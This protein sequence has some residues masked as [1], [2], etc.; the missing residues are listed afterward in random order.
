[1]CPATDDPASCKIHTVIGFLHAEIHHELCAV[2]GRNVMSKGTTR[3]WCRMVKDG[4]TNIKDEVRSGPPFVVSDDQKYVKDGTSQFQ[5]FRVN[6]HTF[7]KLFST[8]LSQLG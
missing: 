8:R 2:Y 6:F 3:Q 7:Q 4:Q 5:N 1:M